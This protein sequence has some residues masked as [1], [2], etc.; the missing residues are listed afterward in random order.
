ML[1]GTF[2]VLQLR[3]ADQAAICKEQQQNSFSEG[4][5]AVWDTNLKSSQIVWL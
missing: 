1:I 2:V 4:A 5:L 3:F